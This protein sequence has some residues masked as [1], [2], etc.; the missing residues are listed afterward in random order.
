[1]NRFKKF[2]CLPNSEKV[3]L[4]KALL[5]LAAVRVILW[6]RPSNSIREP[7]FKISPNSYDPRPSQITPDKIVWAVTIAGQYIP[8]SACLA[9]ALA[10]QIML[11]RAHYPSN[12][13]I[14]VSRQNEDQLEAHAWLESGGRVIMGGSGLERYTKLPIINKEA[15]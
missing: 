5:I 2:F 6:I 13:R 9:K 8:G 11:S 14:G 4:I 1:M 3:L 12:L 10:A 7:F 15:K